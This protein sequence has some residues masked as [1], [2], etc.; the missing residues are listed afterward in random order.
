MKKVVKTI[1]SIFIR[2]KEK[3]IN[4]TYISFRSSFKR[5][6]FCGTNIKI[7]ENVSLSDCLIGDY[8]YI[9]KNSIVS[10]AIIG[11]YCS[12]APGFTCAFGRHP[13][14]SFVSTHP[15]FY[16]K[17]FNNK[18]LDNKFEEYRYIDKKR[19]VCLE[20]GNDVWIG[21]NVIVLD[22]IKIGDGAIITAGAVVTKDVEPY[23]I[24]GGVPSKVIKKRF[25][26]DK[27]DFLLKFKWWDRDKK[28]I[29]ERMELFNNIEDF[30]NKQ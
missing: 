16:S 13:V 22:G 30:I 23:T 4:N 5:V 26:S 17:S 29:D 14:H 19:K 2:I 24:V 1:I 12:I 8:S 27:I 25:D 3:I 7:Y 18:L 21:E 6:K 15:Y 9:G 20:I 28:W 10:K 11:K